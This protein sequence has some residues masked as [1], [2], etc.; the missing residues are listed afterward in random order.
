MGPSLEWGVCMCSEH[1]PKSTSRPS[2]TQIL[3]TNKPSKSNSLEKSH[4]LKIPRG[5]HPLGCRMSGESQDQAHWR[6]ALWSTEL[7]CWIIP[8]TTTTKPNHNT[9]MPQPVLTNYTFTCMGLFWGRNKATNDCRAVLRTHSCFQEARV[10]EVSPLQPCVCRAS[11]ALYLFS[12]LL[13][14]KLSSCL[15]R[16]S[17]QTAFTFLL[18][19]M[20]PWNEN[21]KNVR[22]VACSW[23]A[24]PLIQFGMHL[25]KS[26]FIDFFFFFF[27]AFCCVWIICTYAHHN[28]C[29]IKVFNK[30][31]ALRK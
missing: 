21:V 27:A 11:E 2:P 25:L 1:A 17:L 26:R 22:S 12:L 19:K 4:A 20:F 10:S 16:S 14:K 3:E 5:S 7:Q 13:E 30:F 24:I 15:G 29:Y 28:F 23:E 6:W 18:P 8:Q 31:A 9:A